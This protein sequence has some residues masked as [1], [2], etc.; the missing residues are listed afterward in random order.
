M[1]LVYLTNA[2]MIESTSHWVETQRAKF[3]AIPEIAGLMPKVEAAHKGL[4]DLPKD[5][6]VAVNP[7]AESNAVLDHRQD[8]FLRA[9]YY[10]HRAYREYLLAQ[11]NQDAE[12]LQRVKTSQ[13]ALLPRGMSWTKVGYVEEAGNAKL[14]KETFDKTPA[15]QQVV[16][17]LRLTDAV[18]GRQVLDGWFAAAATLGTAVQAQA[19]QEKNTD[20]EL[21]AK[22]L[23]ARNA[24]ISI[25]RTVLSV[26]GHTDASTSDVLALRGPL[27]Q[28]EEKATARVMARMK[29]PTPTTPTP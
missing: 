6:T 3:L 5:A 26:L 13:K 2:E 29:K 19:G 25:T 10:M 1:G 18:T 27:D 28:I 8:R 12:E 14:A 7:V 20:P 16:G 4:L 15:A 21:G 24:W 22:T 17:K 11:P 23:R 9:V